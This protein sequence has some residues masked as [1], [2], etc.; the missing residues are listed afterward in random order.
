MICKKCGAQI[1]D[2]V[3]FCPNC[4]A[5]MIG[6]DTDTTGTVNNGGGKGNGDDTFNR[7]TN[8]AREAFAQAEN[9][10]SNEFVDVKNTFQNTPAYFLKTDRS[11]LVYILLSFVTCGIYPLYFIYR[12]AQDVNVACEGD[13][14]ETPGLVALVL[15]SI[16]TCGIYSWYWYYKVGNRLANNAERYGLLFQENGTTILLWCLFGVVLCGIGPYV[17]MYILIKNTNAICDAYN[18]TH[19]L[20]GR[21]Y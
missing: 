11:L 16:I 12:L 21:T 2:G 6:D 10:L 7:F 3:R 18:R 4:G 19:G 13:G 15:L 5:S 9:S 20:Y 17:A 8:D 14:E 1:P